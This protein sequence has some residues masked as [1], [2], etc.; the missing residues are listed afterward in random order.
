MSTKTLVFSAPLPHYLLMAGSIE[1]SV[2]KLNDAAH[3]VFLPRLRMSAHIWLIIRQVI[4]S[5]SNYKIQ[6]H[7]ANVT[8]VLAYEL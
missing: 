2:V 6:L 3:L 4:E 1:M 5:H 7:R 8:L